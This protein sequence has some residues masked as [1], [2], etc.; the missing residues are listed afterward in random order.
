M[1]A[2]EDEISRAIAGDAPLSLLLAELEDVERVAAVET[3]EDARATFGRF[4]RAVRAAVRRQEI[5]ACET[6]TRAWIIAPDTARAGARALGS[7][8][9]AAVY[10]A[11]PWRG[12][13]LVASVGVAV[14]GE[15]G[16]TTAELIIAA[17][18]ARYAAEAAG[19]EM[20]PARPQPEPGV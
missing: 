20:A 7:R 4:A 16:T 17:E 12:A 1:G 11:E 14:L 3:P 5:L 2:L 6:D 18:E 19:V 9:A 15:D 13:P 8:I 10:G